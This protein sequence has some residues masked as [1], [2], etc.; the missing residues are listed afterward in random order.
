MDKETKVKLVVE[1]LLQKQ[2]EFGSNY[3]GFFGFL[4]EAALMPT[5]E[6]D[7]QLLAYAEAKKAKVEADKASLEAQKLDAEQ[8]LTVMSNE[9]DAVVSALKVDTGVK[10]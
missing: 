6:V 5:E 3:Q 1:L 10:K 9:L 4:A 2:A 7:K 8:K